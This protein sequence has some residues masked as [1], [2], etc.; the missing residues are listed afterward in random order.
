MI[1]SLSQAFPVGDQVGISSTKINDS[2]M[3]S[4][5]ENPYCI[6]ILSDITYTLWKCVTNIKK[7]K[8]KEK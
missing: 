7:K 2:N 4:G 5:R 6:N 8:R 1:W 3:R